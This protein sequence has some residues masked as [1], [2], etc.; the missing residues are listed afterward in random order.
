MAEARD[1][2]ALARAALQADALATSVSLA[3]YAMLNASRAALSEDDL[4]AKTHSGTWHLFRETFVAS[5]RF[6]AELARDAERT[7]RLRIRADYEAGR[8]DRDV[9]EAV[10][11][12]GARFVAAIEALYAD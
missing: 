6:D 7:Q 12:L 9:A 8:F 11:E 1:R 2:L 3:Y 10:V 5:G 4:Y